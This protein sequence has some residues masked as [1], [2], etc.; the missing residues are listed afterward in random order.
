VPILSSILSNKY[1]LRMPCFFPRFFLAVVQVPW[2]SNMIECHVTPTS[3]EAFSHNTSLYVIINYHDRG[4]YYQGLFL[5]VN[6]ILSMRKI[7]WRHTACLWRHWQVWKY[8]RS[9]DKWKGYKLRKWYE[10]TKKVWKGCEEATKNLGCEVIKLRDNNAP[11]R[12][13]VTESDVNRVTGR[14]PDRK[15]PEPEVK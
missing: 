10:V 12:S 15:S 4:R 11:Y 2:L 6:S 13:H 14:G 3:P 9:I 5:T 1:V 8:H 7:D